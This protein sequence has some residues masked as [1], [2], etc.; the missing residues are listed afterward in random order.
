MAKVNVT[1]L[2]RESIAQGLASNEVIAK[3]TQAYVD[4]GRDA[5]YAAKRA[6]DTYKLETSTTKPP[7][8]VI[9]PIEQ[10]VQATPEVVTPPAE[11]VQSE[12]TADTST[13]EL[14]STE[15]VGDDFYDTEASDLYDDENVEN[16]FRD[17]EEVE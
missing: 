14:Q 11:V 16:D 13:I 5:K 9:T 1:K 3:L 7:V 12:A 15:E 6:Q 10:T 4:A 2:C 8:Q 17:I